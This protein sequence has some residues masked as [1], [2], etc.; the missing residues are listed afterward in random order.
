M[1]LL[2]LFPNFGELVLDAQL[3]RLGHLVSDGGII[4]MKFRRFVKNFDIFGYVIRLRFNGKGDSHRTLMGGIV[5]ISIYALILVYTM[6]LCFLCTKWSVMGK[7]LTTLSYF[8]VLINICFWA[9]LRKSRF[10]GFLRVM[11]N[12]FRKGC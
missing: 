1:S 11:K 3:V 2:F 9:L 8:R 6:F 4:N 10:F 5:S 12:S 7:I